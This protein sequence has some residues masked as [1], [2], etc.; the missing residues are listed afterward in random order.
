MNTEPGEKWLF[1]FAHPDDDSLICGSMRLIKERGGDV[2]A[3]W[4]VSG[5]SPR[6]IK[7]RE[8]EVQSAMDLVGISRKNRYFLRLPVCF[9]LNFSYSKKRLF[10]LVD[11]INPA[12]IVVPAFE[13]GHVDHDATNFLGVESAKHLTTRNPNIIVYEYPL[14]NG[15]GPVWRWWWNIN[16][17]PSGVHGAGETQYTSLL[18]P[19]IDL[20]YQLMKTYKSQWMYM[21][22]ARIACSRTRLR[23]QG[24]PFR[25]VS[26]DRNF[27]VRPHRG[28]LNTERW[29]NFWMGTSFSEF[30]ELTTKAKTE[31]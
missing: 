28:K 11:S 20:K 9:L 19:V 17:F 21:I 25:L 31:S 5:L 8:K 29:F 18:D 13:G 24:E 22:P 10:P 15:D 3:V 7:V 30:T 16:V 1:I 27:T 14:Y 4:L 6:G 12:K 23:K 2:H 26:L